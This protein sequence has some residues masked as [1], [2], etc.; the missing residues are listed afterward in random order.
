MKL[1]F[2]PDLPWPVFCL[3]AL[4]LLVSGCAE[5]LR[6]DVITFYENNLPA[7]ETIRIEAVDPARGETLE[8]RQYAQQVSN[9]LTDVGYQVVTEGEAAELLALLDYSVETG[10]LDIRLQN[11]G[12]YVRYH[13]YYGRYRDPFYFGMMNRWNPEI[14]STP[15]YIR[16][17]SLVIVRNDSDREHLFEGRVESVGRERRLPEV[18]PYLVTALFSNF[19]GESG[20]TKV[21]SIEMDR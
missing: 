8:F 15:S 16:S 14:Y 12:P 1:K 20:V 21:V 5:T 2:R 7:G 10:P 18:M 4:L 13:F 11:D 19:P 3:S 17:L 9:G 6:S